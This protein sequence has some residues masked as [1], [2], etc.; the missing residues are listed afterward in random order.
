MADHMLTVD[1]DAHVLEPR[2]T[3]IDYIDPKFRD[4]AI[5]IDRDDRG[6]ELLLIDN[7]PLEGLRN[8]LAA[9]GGIELDPADALN[10][11]LNLSYEDGIPAGGNNPA[12]RLKVMDS[13][14]IDIALVYPT[15][16]I[17]WEGMVTDGDLANAYTRAYNRY[18]VDFCSHD[19]SRLVPVAHLSLIDIDG[20]IE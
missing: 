11:K 4:R 17:C 1:A 6:D 7:R 3:W 15:I 13:E 19:R 20:A 8:S 9:L 10:R 5:R 14:Q 16:G 12:E 2:N 18:I